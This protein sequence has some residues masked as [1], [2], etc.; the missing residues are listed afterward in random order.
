MNGL[1]TALWKSPMFT[2]HMSGYEGVVG[3]TS[4]PSGDLG[5]F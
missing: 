4:P 5:G 1:K 3:L 2:K